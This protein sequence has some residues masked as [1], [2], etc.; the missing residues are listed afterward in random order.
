M[1]N[2]VVKSEKVIARP[3]SEVR[4][5]FIDFAHHERAGIHKG[6]QV[7]N[8]RPLATGCQYTG[9]R[10]VFGALQEDE[11]EVRVNPDGSST[12]RSI[13]GT[14]VGTTIKQ[15]FESQGPNSTLVRLEVDMPLKGLFRLLAPL[16]RVG[17]QQDLKSA[18]EEDRIDLEERGYTRS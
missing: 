9:R 14:N 1:S 17:I 6:F 4:S 10:R 5:Q 2:I 11:F 7:S 8:V 16:M 12:M 3:I 13:S 15:T 18:L